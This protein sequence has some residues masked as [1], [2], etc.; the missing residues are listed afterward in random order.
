MGFASFQT[1]NLPLTVLKVLIYGLIVG[2]SPSTLDDPK[3]VEVCLLYLCTYG[4]DY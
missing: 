2:L 1:S 4:D 3:K